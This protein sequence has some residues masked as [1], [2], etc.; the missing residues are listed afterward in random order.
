MIQCT[1]C[2][3]EVSEKD[4]NPRDHTVCN[5]CLIYCSD[6]YC[7]EI[8]NLKRGHS[9]NALFRYPNQP[10]ITEMPFCESCYDSNCLTKCEGCKIMYSYQHLTVKY[11]GA[12]GDDA[13]EW[14]QLFCEKC[15]RLREQHN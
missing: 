15:I 14:E 11:G 10:Y 6:S 4:T 1:I 2:R 13:P 12:F 8:T 7:M 3:Q 5:T 9:W